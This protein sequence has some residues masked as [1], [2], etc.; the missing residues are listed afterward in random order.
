MNSQVVLKSNKVLKLDTQRIRLLKLRINAET[1][2]YSIAESREV[3]KIKLNQ[4]Q[5]K[6]EQVRSFLDSLRGGIL[7]ICFQVLCI[8]EDGMDFCEWRSM[9]PEIRENITNV[10]VMG[11]KDVS[12]MNKFINAKLG[13]FYNYDFS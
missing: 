7:I 12:I 1:V 8:V 9:L 11:L 10:L 2:K 6:N 3:S 4:I 5:I 13:M